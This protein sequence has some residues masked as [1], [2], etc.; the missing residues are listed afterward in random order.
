MRSCCVTDVGQ[1]EPRA[2]FVL[3]PRPPV[4]PLPNLLIIFGRYGRTSGRRY[5]IRYAAS[6]RQS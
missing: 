1:K 5:G 6:D 2:S 4:G 3:L